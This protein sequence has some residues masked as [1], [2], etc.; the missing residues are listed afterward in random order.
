RY[1]RKLQVGDIGGKGRGFVGHGVSSFWNASYA[2][3]RALSSRHR[4][5]GIS[6]ALAY[7]GALMQADAMMARGKWLIDRIW[8]WRTELA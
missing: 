7:S 4:G 5:V 3:R 8:S 1:I 2:G 6:H